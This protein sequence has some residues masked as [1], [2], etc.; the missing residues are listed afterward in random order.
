MKNEQIQS[1]VAIPQ[2]RQF[3]NRYNLSAN[4]VEENII[5][6]LTWK[7]EIIKC[8]GC[9]SLSFCRQKLK[10]KVYHLGFDENG[11]LEER[12]I[13]CSFEKK[14]EEMLAHRKNFKISHMS[15]MDYLIE[16]EN[17]T[18]KIDLK[19]EYLKT[20]QAV[21]QS[22]RDPKGLYLYGQAGVGKSYMMKA[23]CN[24]YAKAGKTVS[25]VKVPLWVKTMKESFGQEEIAQRMNRALLK[26]DVVIFDDI[27]SESISAWTLN[28]LLF[29]ILDERMEKKKKTYFTSNYSME[30]LQQKYAFIEKSDKVG[31][32]RVM[33]RIRTLANGTLLSGS[34]LR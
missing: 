30:E 6:F 33:E 18:K 32:D 8:N 11:Y 14:K 12:Y 28:E 4:F 22:E 20:L 29:P 31:A 34:S 16:I 27:G 1:I 3:L 23:L 21:I 2:I 19:S 25:F 10:G 9:R 17:L 13:S 15:E 26:S 5:E 24:Y 7:E